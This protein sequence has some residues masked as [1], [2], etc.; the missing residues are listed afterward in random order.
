VLL[1]IAALRV[2][3]SGLSVTRHAKAMAPDELLLIKIDM[4]RE[5]ATRIDESI[6]SLEA[7]LPRA[8]AA[9]TQINSAI[10]TIRSIVPD[11]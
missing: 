8:Q 5:A 10:K 11:R 1:V 3:F 7:L 9:L 2:T 6:A 4:A